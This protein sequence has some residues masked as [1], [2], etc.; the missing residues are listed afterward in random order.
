MRLAAV[1][2]TLLL[3][4]TIALSIVVLAANDKTDDR[5]SSG[6][7]KYDHIFVIV[8]ENEEAPSII[9]NANAPTINQLAQRYG[10]ATNFYAVIH[11]SEGN[12]IALTDADAHGVTDDN[13]YITHQFSNPTL[14]DRLEAA[15]LSWKGYFQNMPTPGFLGT[16]Y[17]GTDSNCLYASKHNGFLNFSQIVGNPAELQKM[18]PDSVL[19]DDLTTRN[20]PSYSFIVPDQCHDMHGLDNICPDNATNIRVADEYLRTLVDEIMSSQTWRAGHNAIVVTF[21][22]GSSALGCCG[23]NPGG[24]QIVTIVV[25]NHQNA[26]LQDATPFNHYSLVA[27]IEKAFGVPCTQ[28]ACDAVNVPT[29]DML[30]DL[31]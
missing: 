28:N 15:G 6:H 20:V 16:C 10:I 8:E 14:V 24:G 2:A 31:Q 3:G 26:A 5:T 21:D 29:M 23:A 19:G 9:G 30:F 12:Y 1:I 27:T 18:V 22:E 4:A 13:S 25:T 11:P 7:A 17:P